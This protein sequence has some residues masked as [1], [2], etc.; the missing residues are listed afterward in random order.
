MTKTEAA[1]ILTAESLPSYLFKKK[2]SI[3]IL[4]DC[5][6]ESELSA[7]TIAGG[8]VNYAFQVKGP[9]GITIFVKQAPEFVAIFGPDGFPLTSERMQKEMDVYNEWK[10]ILKEKKEQYLP[11]I[12]MFDRMNM[13]VVMEFF[14][15][16]HLF[17]DVLVKTGE[18]HQAVASGLGEFMGKTHA[19]THSSVVSEERKEFL[20]K[21]FENRAMRDVQLEFVF[22]KCYKE[23]TDEQRAGL[24]LDEAFMNEVQTLKTAYD[25][26][27]LDG[28][29][30]CGHVLTHGD[31]HPGSVMVDAS[32]GFVKVI[33]PEFCVYGPPGL[34]VGSL[35]SGFVLAAVHHA[36]NDE[37]DFDKKKA[38]TSIKEGAVA[39]WESYKKA[40]LLNDSLSI[41]LVEKIG[42]ETVGFTVA[43]VCRTA[44]GFAGGRL[45]LQ[46]EDPTVKAAAIRTAMG[47]VQRCMTKRHQG[48]MEILFEE[49]ETLSAYNSPSEKKCQI[50]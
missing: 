10:V 46:F 35:L 36:H 26:K 1:P 33:D 4:A 42:A 49:L 45:W 34:D 15:G 29:E 17:D 16:F 27:N 20:T 9:S 39:V 43:E 30:S 21:S 23:A 12:Y 31:L 8:N 38:V 2:D 18:V 11:E 25:G 5:Q 24:I 41:E 6:S 14:D 7:S 44:L 28:P 50:L 13:V 22:T 32:K 48:G 40:I 47:I 37:K 19:A 3:S